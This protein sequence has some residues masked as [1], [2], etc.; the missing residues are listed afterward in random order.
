MDGRNELS[1]IIP[2]HPPT[3]AELDYNSPEVRLILYLHGQNMSRDA[4]LEKRQDRSDLYV[5]AGLWLFGIAAV[6]FLD[7][8]AALLSHGAIP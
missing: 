7:L 5:K 3:S 8:I 4:R 1:F 2:E 6:S